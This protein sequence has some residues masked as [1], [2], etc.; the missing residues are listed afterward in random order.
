MRKG[1][2]QEMEPN[3]PNESSNESSDED[4]FYSQDLESQIMSDPIFQEQQAGPSEQLE[5]KT[6]PFNGD[7]FSNIPP[8]YEALHKKI[9]QDVVN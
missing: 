6:T 3:D 7:N 2:T 5:N 1:E 8:L 9:L 4:T